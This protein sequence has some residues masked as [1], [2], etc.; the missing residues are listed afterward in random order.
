M[1][2]N[3]TKIKPYFCVLNKYKC[4]DQPLRA[5][6]CRV[7]GYNAKKTQCSSE[8]GF[9]AGCVTY[10][11][12]GGCYLVLTGMRQGTESRMQ[13][14]VPGSA[15]ST[16]TK[17]LSSKVTTLRCWESSRGFRKEP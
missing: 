1:E 10:S 3:V 16:M 2:K 17:G 12:A 6:P 4:P 7:F 14:L 13:E 8:K 5:E 9:T 11:A 15:G